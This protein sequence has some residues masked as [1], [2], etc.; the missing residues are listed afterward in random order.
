MPNS[1]KFVLVVVTIIT[2]FAD[3]AI[4][5]ITGIII[6]ALV[7]AWNHSKVRSRVYKDGDDTKVYEFDGPLFFGST[8]SFFE[9]FDLKHDPKIVILDFKDSRV[10]DISGVEAIDTITKKYK[11]AGKVLS[12]RHLSEDCKKILKNAGPFCEY[13]ENDPNYKVAINY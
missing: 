3:L 13:N 1:D 5:V 6:S 12:I 4:A 8:T 7:F 2:I 9:L 10:M 11:E